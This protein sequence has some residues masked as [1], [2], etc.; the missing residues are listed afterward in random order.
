VS[1]ADATL[2]RVSTVA[3]ALSVTG[4]ICELAGLAL[5]VFDIHRDREHAKR[6]FVPQQRRHPPKRSYPSKVTPGPQV[7]RP[8]LG[9]VSYGRADDQRRAL[10][11]L[12]NSVAKID[13]AAVNALIGMQKTLDAQLDEA[14]DDLREEAAK[15]DD[16]LREHLYYVLA[17]SIADRLRGAALLGVGIVLATLGSVVS[18]LS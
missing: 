18:T 4:G 8:W 11:W 7:G 6:L 16:H 15:S 14:I 5:V 2:R 13:A 9:G 10:Q 3:V 12:A 17:G 1:G